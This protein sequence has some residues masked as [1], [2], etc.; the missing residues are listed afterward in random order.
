MKLWTVVSNGDDGIVS[1]IAASAEDAARRA[2]VIASG[3]WSDVRSDDMPENWQAA[4]EVLTSMPFFMDGVYVQEHEVEFPVFVGVDLASG[5]DQTVFWV[6]YKTRADLLRFEHPAFSHLGA[7][8]SGNPC[9]WENFYRCDHMGDTDDEPESWQSEWSCQCDDDCPVCGRSCEPDESVWLV[10]IDNSEAKALWEGL[11]E[12]GALPSADPDPVRE[13]YEDAAAQMEADGIAREEERLKPHEILGGSQWTPDE[14]AAVD[15]YAA[16]A[17]SRSAPRWAW[18]IIDE[19]LE[20]DSMS[21]A[22]DPNLRAMIRA[23]TVAMQLACESAN[24]EPIT[25]SR[26]DDIINGDGR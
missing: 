9:V 22:F 8:T 17:V 24:D 26:V 10:S 12:A 16:E 2:H 21:S 4:M 11:P 15:D 18:E 1:Q 13:A 5:P 23:S 14:I 25:R 19:T 7:D 3:F 20:A 6:P